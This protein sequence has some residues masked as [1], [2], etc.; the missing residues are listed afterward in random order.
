[1]SFSAEFLRVIKPSLIGTTSLSH[2][3]GTEAQANH[4][5]QKNRIFDSLRTI[6]SF[7]AEENSDLRAYFGRK[8][9]RREN[10]PPAVG[11]EVVLNCGM[12]G[13]VIN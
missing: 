11:N 3:A 12:T 6:K 4:D 1:M 5:T 8:F 2:S 10:L 9:L 13:A 7:T